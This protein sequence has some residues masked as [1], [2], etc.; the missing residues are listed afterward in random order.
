MSRK[1]L[2]R[3]LSALFTQTTQLESDLIEID[4]DQL[5][6]AESQPRKYFDEKKLNEL[7]I[8]IKANGIIQPIVA[9][10]YG[11][12]FQI[13][14]GERRWRAAKMAGL[15]K[16]PCIIKEVPEANILEISLIENIQRQE[17]NPI[18][19][20]MA[21]KN[22]L[23][24]LNVT[25]EE[26]AQR[27]GKDRSSITNVLRLLR[28]PEDIQRLVEEDKL[29]MGHARA[30]LAIESEDIQRTL[31]IE[32]SNKNLSV[33]ETERIVKARQGSQ[34]TKNANNDESVSK[35]DERAN[36]EAAEFKLSKRLGA[37]VKIKFQKAG[38]LVEIKFASREDL[39]R[40]FDI[41]IQNTR[42]EGL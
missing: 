25:Q 7:A 41:L 13:I 14:A 16:I 26:I 20:A 42:P 8:S 30:L 12:R 17:L 15:Q 21:Y 18:E 24:R 34:S 40:L 19:E 10:R 28:L 38:G 23:E 39:A 36:V 6:P 5:E 2:G 29:S 27:V 22:L 3:G 9:R 1:A 35:E 32:I 33:R 31:A 4:L 11:D 37:Q